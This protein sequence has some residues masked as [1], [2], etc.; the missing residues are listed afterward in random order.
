MPSTTTSDAADLA[1]SFTSP[2]LRRRRFELLP[3]RGEGAPYTEAQGRAPGD[4][5]APAELA[6]LI[7]SISEVGLL[8]PVLAEEIPSADGA[9]PTMRIVAGERRLRAARW[10]A[11]NLTDNPHFAALPAIVCPGPLS[12]EER[13]IWQL[14]ENLA[15]EPLQPGEQA[16]ALLYQR[17]ALLTVK[18]LRCG[19]PV[20]RE[21]AELTD[22]VERYKALERI[23]GADTQAAAPWGEVLSRLGLQLSPRRARELVR[24]FAALPPDISEEMDAER[25]ALH[26]RIRFVQLQQGRAQAAAEI[27]AA[28][29]ETG[30]TELLYAATGAA[31]ED[32]QITPEQAL[33]TA[34]ENH[35]EAAEARAAALRGPAAVPG[36]AGRPQTSEESEPGHPRP[37]EE[38]AARLS[39]VAPPEDQDADRSEEPPG[40]DA[41][42]DAVA[43]ACQALRA[44]VR[45][46]HQ[47]AE[48]NR[49]DRG[50]LRLLLDQVHGLLGPAPA[51]RSA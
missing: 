5:S 1:R 38:P 19:K 41:P 21:V 34:A 28:V 26:T 50:S 22:P 30:R 13:R 42:G 17:C 4:S 51:R 9:A 31:L 11:V 6:D 12:E 29:K 15:R 39:L 35:H 7:S 33:A 32:P 3:L 40:L 14:I 49:Y 10:G 18:L 36:E 37:P 44:L 24:A 20:P 23:R 48:I 27:W 46:L 8:Q 45:I 25:V 47:G 2:R 43:D 16:A